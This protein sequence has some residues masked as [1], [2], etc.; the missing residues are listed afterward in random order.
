MFIY[1]EGRE[2]KLF[3]GEVE[4]NTHQVDGHLKFMT[5]LFSSRKILK[6]YLEGEGDIN[7]LLVFTGNRTKNNPATTYYISVKGEDM[8]PALPSYVPVNILDKEYP[9][10]SMISNGSD[11]YHIKK[12]NIRDSYIVNIYNINNDNLL[13]KKLDKTLFEGYYLESKDNNSMWSTDKSGIKYKLADLDNYKVRFREQ[14]VKVPNKAGTPGVFYTISDRK[15]SDNFIRSLIISYTIFIILFCVCVKVTI[16]FSNILENLTYDI[17]DISG[18]DKRKAPW[19]YA[20]FKEYNNILNQFNNL[21]EARESVRRELENSNRDM[22]QKVQKRTEDLYQAIK[23]VEE[24]SKGKMN[25]LAQISHE[26]RTPMNCIIGFC[27]MIIE[28]NDIT[29]HEKYA[30]KII[31]ESETLLKLINDILDDSKIESGK[32]TLECNNVHLHSFLEK[33]TGLGNPYQFENNLD[34]SYNIDSNLPDFIG[35]DELRLYQVV[36]NIYFNALKYTP[37]GSV[38]I[39]AVKS[40]DNNIIISIK[41]TG[42][43]IPENK[44]S[45]IFEDYE[46]LNGKL[47]TR[48]RG[49]GLGLTIT[50]KII[51]VMKGFI[52]VQ[53][54]KGIG[55]CFTIILPYKDVKVANNIPV[56]I[57]KRSQSLKLTGDVLL[58]E[59]YPTNRIIAKKHLESAGLKVYIAENGEEAV[60]ICSQIKFNIILMDIQMPVMDGF[61]ASEKIRKESSVNYETPII[62]MTANS[63]RSVSKRAQNSGMND[64]ILKPIR[65]TSLLE[66]IQ[67][68]ISSKVCN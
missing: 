27:E 30:H 10:V 23:E 38:K 14:L 3:K 51:E 56:L 32:M 39:N 21:I 43:G 47:A 61:T 57:E 12:I 34:V 58:V 53:S 52:E 22:E 16:L 64:I 31:E 35:I 20:Y 60:G 37:M 1:A 63:L 55:S 66:T 7:D 46:R 33:I 5:D 26:I 50:K 68:H 41:D 17:N 49:T 59:D 44:L 62:A 4:N 40:G 67:E 11:F 8:K 29:D 42:I 65:K 45:T 48:F 13:K 36:S 9:K 15:Y 18:G 54:D 2:R 24:A 28:E 25:F 6:R 19:K